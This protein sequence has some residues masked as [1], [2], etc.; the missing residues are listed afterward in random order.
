ME[1]EYFVK[2]GDDEESFEYWRK[3]CLDFFQSL[4]VKK[5]NLKMRDHNKKELSHYSKATSDI[6]YKFP[7][8]VS[9]VWGIANRTDWDLKRHSQ[10]SKK[11]LR[12]RDEK[13][14]ERFF[15]YVIEPSLG[16]ERAL[17]MFL[18]DA[19]TEIEGGRT[20]TTESSK[21]VE[22]VLKLH[23]ALAPIKAAV[24]PLSKKPALQKIAKD[25]YDKL[26][27][28]WMTQYD[29]VSSIGRRYRRQDEIGTPY[30]ITVD[31]DSLEDKKVT[32]RDR[33]TMKQE[34]V[35][36]GNLKTLITQR[37]A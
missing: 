31:F 1:L 12:I 26:C 5:E 22:V 29:E 15:P 27:H 8:G 25:I 37:L 17:L 34:R 14:G 28:H 19:Y 33:D 13:T 11:D 9:E 10:F 7:F 21:E 24:L 4:G 35:K 16:V 6:E 2:P 18:L 32:M 23:K 20:T 36:V 3:L 30:C